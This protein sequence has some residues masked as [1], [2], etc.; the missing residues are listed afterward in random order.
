MTL[1]SDSKYE[2]KLALGSKNNMSNLLNF[3]AS[4]RK[5]QNFHFDVPLLS[6]A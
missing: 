6:I 5:S 2:E 1:K 4:S 3:Y